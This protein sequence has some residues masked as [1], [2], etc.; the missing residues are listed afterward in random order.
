MGAMRLGPLQDLVVFAWGPELEDEQ[1]QQRGPQHASVHQL[2]R[3]LHEPRANRAEPLDAVRDLLQ[4]RRLVRHCEDLHEAHGEVARPPHPAGAVHE[5]SA[6][7]PKG[8]DLIQQELDL[9]EAQLQRAHVPRFRVEEG[10]RVG[11]LLQ[12]ESRE[13][14]R[15]H[16]CQ[17]G[18]RTPREFDGVFRDGPAA[19]EHL[20]LPGRHDVEPSDPQ[21]PRSRR[22]RDRLPRQPVVALLRAEVVEEIAGATEPIGFPVL[23]H[24]EAVLHGVDEARAHSLESLHVEGVVRVHVPGGHDEA[25]VQLH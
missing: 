25:H 1:A 4:G 14:Q 5:H 6:V 17:L 21:P 7:A 15:A 3:S 22:A 20:L 19:G 10:E 9:G 11:A 24:D 8:D 2:F 18:R 13:G 16:A 23:A 12:G